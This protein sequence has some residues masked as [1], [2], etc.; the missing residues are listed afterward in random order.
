MG[1]FAVAALAGFLLFGWIKASQTLGDDSQKLRLQ[2][3]LG[4]LGLL[5]L[6]VLALFVVVLTTQWPTYKVF[7]IAKDLTGRETAQFILGSVFG[8]LLRYWGPHFWE[9]R[10]RPGTRYNWVA[11]SLVGLLLVAAAVPYID[12]QLGGMT[13]L[14]TPVAEFQ[15]AVTTRA[16]NL[17]FKDQRQVYHLKLLPDLRGITTRLQDDI[18]YLDLSEEEAKIIADPS[19]RKKMLKKLNER[20][21]LYD[22][23]RDFI[24][25]TLIPL[26]DCGLAAQKNNLDI[27][28][29]RHALH[30]IAQKLY[31]LLEQGQSLLELQSQV[32]TPAKNPDDLK[33][34]K[35]SWELLRT[36]F[37]KQVKTSW[38]LLSE[39][40]AKEEDKCKL[41]DN[42]YLKGLVDPAV[43][44]KAP[45]I[46]LWLALLNGFNENLEGGISILKDA[47]ERFG[48]E[49]YSPGVLFNI[50]FFLTRYLYDTGHD[51][52]S[53]FLYADKALKIAQDTV[54]RIDK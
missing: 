28:S 36:K 23:T 4:V 51:P 12:R 38:E 26:N 42:K 10:M 8:C 43:L 2:R 14:K 47:S 39:A 53:I 24:D 18:S 11:I 54:R 3:A 15:F 20:R 21:E 13:A 45:H 1:I 30:P 19:G 16:E 40:I 9:M 25:K 41:S 48:S 44:A 22:K 52:K 33:K 29:L 49:D 34:A 27:E 5:A 6:F 35:T 46:Y 37:L 31:L 7:L 32:S 17:T 50:N